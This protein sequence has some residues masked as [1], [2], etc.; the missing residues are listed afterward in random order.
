MVIHGDTMQSCRNSKDQQ[1]NLLKFKSA[2]IVF[3]DEAIKIND[4]P[5]KSSDLCIH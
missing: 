4:T 2:H 5:L 1:G 3:Q